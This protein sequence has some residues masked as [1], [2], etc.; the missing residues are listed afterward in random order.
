MAIPSSYPNHRNPKARAVPE[1]PNKSA[2]LRS[3]ALPRLG[4]SSVRWP[5]GL[6]AS[7]STTPMQRDDSS[8]LV[9]GSRHLPQ[10]ARAPAFPKPVATRLAPRRILTD[11]AS[12]HWPESDQPIRQANDCSPTN[13]KT[14]DA[15]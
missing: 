3:T 14:Y 8:T 6:F 7:A 11:P 13:Q 9:R 10:I 2:P 5:T 4:E 1:L 12:E 15:R